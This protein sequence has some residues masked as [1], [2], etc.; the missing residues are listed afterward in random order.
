MKKIKL[1]LLVILFGSIKICFA[2]N[3]TIYF[4][5]KWNEC[6]KD[7]S[8][9]YRIF[10]LENGKDMVTD[11]QRNGTLQMK[12][13][14]SQR[15]PMVVDGICMYY[16]EKGKLES[17][18][19]YQLNKKLGFWVYYDQVGNDSSIVEHFLNEPKKEIKVTCEYMQYETF[20][21]VEVM[22]EFP[23]GEKGMFEYFR[24][25]IENHYSGL[26]EKSSSTSKGTV[27]VYFVVNTFG[28]AV[29][30]KIVRSAGKDIDE[31]VIKAIEEMPLWK[32]GTQNG[33]LA[34][35]KFTYPIKIHYNP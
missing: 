30:A 9:Y 27:Y 26:K 34:N 16:G 24:K 3:D 28:Q 22:P 19:L 29:N 21:S 8:R 18:G 1:A 11:Y 33:L 4:D 5:K 31:I 25:F 2:Q 23:G 20:I 32:P 12:A 35:V 14:I 17:K 6:A 10:G 7:S 13:Q 15:V